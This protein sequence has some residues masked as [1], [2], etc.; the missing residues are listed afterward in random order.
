MSQI[1]ALRYLCAAQRPRRDGFPG[2]VFTGGIFDI[3]CLRIGL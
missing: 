2:V 3:E 1:A